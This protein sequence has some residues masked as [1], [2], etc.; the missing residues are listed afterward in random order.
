MT[1]TH[2]PTT[3][4]LKRIERPTRASAGEASLLKAS[5]SA[6]GGEGTMLKP[7]GGSLAPGGGSVSSDSSS[8]STMPSSSS[9]PS[10]AVVSSRGGHTSS[11]SDSRSGEGSSVGAAAVTASNGSSSH[12]NCSPLGTP[13]SLMRW[14]SVPSAVSSAPVCSK[15][16]RAAL[17]SSALSTAAQYQSVQAGSVGRSRSA[18][19]SPTSTYSRRPRATHPPQGPCRY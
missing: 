16:L 11:G 6:D 14:S 13:S 2:Q 8:L 7:G 5:I 4:Q 17:L 9:L 1:P 12:E 18:R 3:G 15:Y 19:C 10:R